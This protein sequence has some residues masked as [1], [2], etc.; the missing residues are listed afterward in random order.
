MSQIALVSHQHNHNVTVRMVSQL[1]QPP[2][3]VLIC[4]VLADIVDEEGANGTTVVRRGDRTIPFLTRCVPNLRF[5]GLGVDLN[6]ACCE[7][8]T[9][10]R[11]GVE[12]ELIA[13]ETAEQVRF[14]NTG[15]SDKHD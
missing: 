9:D 10:G 12:V 13:S 4:L 7:F 11:L 6:G 14:T 15:V 5:N 3:D 8:N 2:L 1:F